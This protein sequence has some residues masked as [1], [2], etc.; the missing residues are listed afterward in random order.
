MDL[1]EREGALATL[2]AALDDSAAG[3]GRV[4]VVAGE[5]G[6]GK[7]ALVAAAMDAADGTRRILTG[8]C[9]PLLTPRALG[10]F[11]D[12][13]RQGGGALAAAFRDPGGREELVAALLGE[14]SAAPP[15]V[16]VVEDA[17]W[18]DE[19]TLDLL[20][21]L[22]RRV[23]ATTGTL[24]VTLRPERS[25]DRVRA[26]LGQLP[27]G[28]VR[29]I[30]LH[31]LP[32]PAVAELARRAGRSAADLHDLTGGNPFFVTEVLAAPGV[33]IPGSVRDAVLARAHRLSS[34][35]RAVLDVVGV[36][37]GRAETWLVDEV[38]GAAAAEPVDECVGAGMLEVD[39]EAVRFRH[40]IA[41]SSIEDELTPMRRRDLDARV[42]AALRGRPPIDPARLVHHARRAGD[43]AAVVDAAPDA[44]RLAAASGAHMQAAA[45]LRTALEAA[46][47][48]PEARRAE[49]LEALSVEAYLCGTPGE[50][51]TARR[52]ALAIRTALGQT[53][54]AG[55]DER[56]LSRL[57]WWAGRRDESEAAA[58]RAI[59]LLEPLG[60]SRGLA[61]AYSTLSQLLM[62][63]WRNAD[64]ILWGERAIAL[65]RELG[66]REALAHGLTNVGTAR[67][68][69]G[70]AAGRAMLEEAAAIATADGDHDNAVRA[71]VNLAWGDLLHRRYADSATSVARGLAF[72]RANELRAYV[73]YLLGMRAWARLE[74]GDWAG[75]EEDGREVV[76]I[77][78][79]HPAISAHPG[80]VTLGRL[81][82]R[83]GDPE[84]DELLD[85]AWRRAAS[86]AEAQRVQ[87]AAI[88]CAE[89]AWL[90]GDAEGLRR[91]A[92]A[93]VAT[94]DVSAVPRMVGESLLWA[95]RAGELD[96]DPA[97]AEEPLRRSI[98]GDPRGAAAAWEEL[99]CV[100]DAADA[101][102]DSD[103][104]DDLRRAL[105]TFDRLGATVPAAR[106][107]ARL[108]D[109]GHVVPAGPRPATRSDPD[110]LTPRQ[111]EILALVAEGLT[112][113][114][115]ADRLVISE[116]TVDHHVAA[117]L[118]KLGVASRAQAAAAAAR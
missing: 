115:I 91:Y 34:P 105:E 86:A 69:S 5:A 59:A 88:A 45:H 57:L 17:H 107:R 101:L 106:V 1:L 44:A 60:P 24:V 83:R 64:A 55:E 72:A 36:V 25:D 46:D 89:R 94:L 35:A 104:E 28:V 71:I 53:A 41:R 65:A 61:M 7:T 16:L 68:E 14:L 51:L 31:P 58:G 112:N 79:A 109:A 6:I 66:D 87:P 113:A 8:A 67:V 99:G 19:A 13:A 84:G 117:V 42:L 27:G 76:A 30:D 80:I 20:A 74:L 93:A 38:L 78:G 110:G 2:S 37:P 95:W 75:A 22:G 114:Q 82:V 100:Y 18:A 4:V 103:D 116:R 85:V 15:R 90:R 43:R 48:L 81:L 92:A 50:A 32:P 12:I 9:D 10:P 47:A 97:G 39:G 49:L 56:W 29:R 111:R 33:A 3:S 77:D 102:T 21:V 96:R 26:T 23:G 62:L 40:E 108:R 118:R 52:E 98:L 63:A 11:H 54:E 73:Q 70:D